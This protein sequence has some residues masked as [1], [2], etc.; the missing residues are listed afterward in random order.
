[1]ITVAKKKAQKPDVHENDY[2]ARDNLKKVFGNWNISS[3]NDYFSNIEYGQDSLVSIVDGTQI[4]NAEFRVQSKVFTT[5][6]QV[7]GKQLSTRIKVSTLNSLNDISVPVILH[8]FD[9]VNNQAYWVWFHEWYAENYNETWETRDKITVSILKKGNLLTIENREEI[10]HYVLDEHNKNL[11]RKSA[12]LNSKLDPDY[13]FDFLQQDDQ[14]IIILRPKHN[15]PRNFG[16]QLSGNNVEE[17]ARAINQD[18]FAEFQGHI[19]FSNLPELN[20]FALSSENGFLRFQRAYPQNSLIRID[21]LNNKD[22]AYITPSTFKA[23]YKALS[24]QKLEISGICSETFINFSIVQDLESK[25]ISF[26]AIA[27]IKMDTD[28]V[29]INTQ[30]AKFSKILEAYKIRVNF[31][32]ESVE[33]LIL[34]ADKREIQ[35][36]SYLDSEIHSLVRF[37]SLIQQEIGGKIFLPLYVDSNVINYAEAIFQGLETGT[38]SYLSEKNILTVNLSVIDKDALKMIEDLSHEGVAIMKLPIDEPLD[39]YGQKLQ[40]GILEYNLENLKCL[41]QQEAVD[42]LIAGQGTNEIIDLALKFE[43]DYA[44][45]QIKLLDWQDEEVI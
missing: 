14:N 12:Q 41:N 7:K 19:K 29:F 25:Q 45:A 1:M 32:E 11:L 44:H 30:L 34:L 2:R 28:V 3:M 38:M 26:N 17:F 13:S 15:K 5:E 8:F 20:G 27:N 23:V 4:T 18:Q 40:L 36:I 22:I 6:K 10:Q 9:N 43:I 39:F 35:N 16:I 33:P 42:K 21:F 37:L 24:P 31:L